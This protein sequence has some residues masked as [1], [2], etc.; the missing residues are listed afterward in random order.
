[1][2]YGRPSGERRAIGLGSDARRGA[3]G[4][5]EAPRNGRD[6][7][8][9]YLVFPGTRWRFEIVS[10]RIDLK[11]DAV[12]FKAYAGEPE[13]AMADLSAVLGRPA[14]GTDLRIE[15]HEDSI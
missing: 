11:G 5:T 8:T 14:R 3:G 7:M 12:D 15:Y 6:T 1:M 4:D 2:V 13:Q 9:R 10:T